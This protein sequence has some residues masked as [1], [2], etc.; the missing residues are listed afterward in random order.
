MRFLLLYFLYA[1]N[2]Y[3]SFCSNIVF[4]DRDIIRQSKSEHFVIK[5]IILKHIVL[6]FIFEKD[7]G[8]N[9]D[10][11]LNRKEMCLKFSTNI[12]KL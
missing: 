3:R 8:A 6:L 11:K 9:K 4:L 12:A 1:V 10:L 7:V 5:E 2:F